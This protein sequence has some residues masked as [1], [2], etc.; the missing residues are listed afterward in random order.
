MSWPG[1]GAALVVV[2]GTRAGGAE[3][4]AGV[5]LGSESDE[6]TLRGGEAAGS[7]EAGGEKAGG[8][9]IAGEVDGTSG[10]NSLVRSAAAVEGDG[11]GEG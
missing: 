10:C 11:C 6:L 2:E 5:R 7:E 3:V 8:E 1:R 4:D 9:V